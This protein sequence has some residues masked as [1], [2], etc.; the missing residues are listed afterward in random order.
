MS[1]IINHEA[2]K[3]Q[4]PRNLVSQGNLKMQSTEHFVT[5]EAAGTS[6]ERT[7]LRGEAFPGEQLMKDMR[8]TS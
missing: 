8:N 6:V 5:T 3:L 4:I 1:S 2:D 7:Q